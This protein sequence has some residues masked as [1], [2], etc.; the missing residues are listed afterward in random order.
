MPG[1]AFGQGSDAGDADAAGDQ[2]D[3]G[4][5]QRVEAG[6]RERAV[7]ADVHVWLAGRGA[8]SRGEAAWL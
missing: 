7:D 3:V 1:E 6:A 2:D 8:R 4:V 5:E